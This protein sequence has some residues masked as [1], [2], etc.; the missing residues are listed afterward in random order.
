M[1]YYVTAWC[2]QA[3]SFFEHSSER[4]D[5]IFLFH[6]VNIPFHH[7]KI[8]KHNV[9]LYQTSSVRDYSW[10]LQLCA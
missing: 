8:N 3:L 4:A 2:A 1:K 6:I 5:V 9:V 10:I 7:V